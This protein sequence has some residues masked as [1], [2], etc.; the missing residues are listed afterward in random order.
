[1]K[2]VLTQRS[3]MAIIVAM[4]HY[5]IA[6]AKNRLPSLVSA[7]ERGERVTITRY[8]RPVAELRPVAQGRKRVGTASIDWLERQ[9]ADLPAS[10]EDSVEQLD[11][12]RGERLPE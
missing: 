7:S 12:L 5:S 9:L 10:E 11:A 8:G 3:N 4:T 1:M 6:D 2:P